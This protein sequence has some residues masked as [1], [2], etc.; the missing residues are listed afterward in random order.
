M[1]VLTLE[2]NFIPYSLIIYDR[3]EEEEEEEKEQEVA[4]FLFS[5]HTGSIIRTR[6]CD[7]VFF[8]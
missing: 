7:F 2:K 3:E 5:L 8:M 6:K 4:L 1:V